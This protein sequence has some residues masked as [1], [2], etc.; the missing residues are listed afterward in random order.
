MLK[1][2]NQKNVKVI[3]N[4]DNDLKEIH[5]FYRCGEDIHCLAFIQY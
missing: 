1:Y 4:V 2:S 3:K 5:N